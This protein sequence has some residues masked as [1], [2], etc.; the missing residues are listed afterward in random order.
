MGL[1]S[2]RSY[3]PDRLRKRQQTCLRI[4]LD[5]ARN[6]YFFDF[7]LEL[8]NHVF[9]FASNTF[10]KPFRGTNKCVRNNRYRRF[11]QHL[12]KTVE[13]NEMSNVT[14]EFGVVST[15]TTTLTDLIQGAVTTKEERRSTTIGSTVGGN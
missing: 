10:V 9:I 13:V 3:F 5:P 7:V 15:L 2:T 8:M 14:T 1:I 12:L 4:L 6:S 11:F